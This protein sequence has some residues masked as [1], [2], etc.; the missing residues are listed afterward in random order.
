M[1]SASWAYCRPQGSKTTHGRKICCHGRFFCTLAHLLRGEVVPGAHAPG[2][3]LMGQPTGV[4]AGGQVCTSRKGGG[5]LATCGWWKLSGTQVPSSVAF[6][7]F[8]MVYT[9]SLYMH[10]RYL[11]TGL[12][13]RSASRSSVA[14]DDSLTCYF[15][16][17]LPPGPYRASRRSLDHPAGQQPSRGL[18]DMLAALDWFTDSEMP[19]PDGSSAMW[20]E[21]PMMRKVLLTVVFSP[22]AG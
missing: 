1:G 8:N 16:L 10:V 17:D 19:R 5:G 14:T 20:R 15:V 3:C 22:Q 21:L 4:A 18:A 12:S 9:C 11:S 7:R 2:T 6:L 13:V